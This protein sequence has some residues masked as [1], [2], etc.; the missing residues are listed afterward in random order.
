MWVGA[1]AEIVSSQDHQG[2]HVGGWG[3]V[4]ET[5]RLRHY[6]QKFKISNLA[7]YTEIIAS[8]TGEI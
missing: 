1:G 5:F 2:Q 6:R 3:V 7:V 8:R 4:R